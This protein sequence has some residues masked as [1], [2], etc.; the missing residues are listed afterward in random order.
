MK[1]KIYYILLFI[2]LLFITRTNVNAYTYGGCEYSKISRLKSI[3]SNINLSY[4]YYIYDNKAYFNVTINNVVP[5]IYFV[6]SKTEKKYDYTNS[7]DGEIV[8]QGYTGENGTYKFYSDL[9]ECR[10][11]KLGNKYYSFPDYNYYYNTSICLDNPSYSLC[12]KWIKVTTSYSELE[13]KINE[14]KQDQ[15]LKEDEKEETIIYNKTIIDYI[16]EYY[17]KYYYIILVGII[18][19]C[20]TIM[21]ISRRKNR[22]DI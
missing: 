13:K 19:V 9:E 16:V 1:K 11:V 8:I 2:T 14:Y 6:D 20:V 10:S 7:I 15:E 22:F 4:D 3:V 18:V 5:G 12:K 21:I 17:V